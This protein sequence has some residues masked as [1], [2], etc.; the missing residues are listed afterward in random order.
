MEGLIGED[1]GST[2]NWCTLLDT[3]YDLGVSYVLEGERH[4]RLRIPSVEI[5]KLRL[6]QMGEDSVVDWSIAELEII[7]A[8]NS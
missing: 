7:K 8:P 2:Q 6:K 5:S 1:N 3:R 4:L